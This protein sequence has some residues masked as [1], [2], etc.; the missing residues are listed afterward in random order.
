MTYFFDSSSY[1]RTIMEEKILPSFEYEFN[2]SNHSGLCSL[3]EGIYLL[4]D[5]FVSTISESSKV[6]ESFFA[7]AQ[8]AVQKDVERGF[9]VLPSRWASA[10]MSCMFH[11]RVAVSET[12]IGAVV[13]HNMVVASRR[14]GYE[15]KLWRLVKEAMEKGTSKDC[16]CL[17]KPFILVK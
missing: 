5:T 4:W 6:K 8:E 3:V 12:V 11:D 13:L 15:S 17:N 7:S 1:V 16:D 10:M 14:N 2:G 9:R